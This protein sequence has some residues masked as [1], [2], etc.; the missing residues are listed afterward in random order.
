MDFKIDSSQFEAISTLVGKKF[1]SNQSHFERSLKQLGLL[2]STTQSLVLLITGI[3]GI[4]VVCKFDIP[5][6]F[7]IVTKEAF[8][9]ENAKLANA[10]ALVDLERSRIE[11]ELAELDAKEKMK[12]VIEIR[13]YDLILERGDVINSE[14]ISWKGIFS[15]E[16]VN[17]GSYGVD[18]TYSTL[19]LF[20]GVIDNSLRGINEF[21]L[22]NPPKS[23]FHKSSESSS[24]ASLARPITWNRMI[25][26]ASTT[27]DLFA[28]TTG[29]EFF[30]DHLFDDVLLSEGLLVGYLASG[31]S[32]KFEQEFT[33]QASVH[34]YIGVAF[35]FGSDDNFVVNQLDDFVI[36]FFELDQ[37][38]ANNSESEY[39]TPS[40]K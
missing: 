1:S 11:S 9:L 8:Q 6:K 15:L 14:V 19:E 13:S 34:D 5:T 26:I 29:E 28:S 20:S 33:F 25:G 10:Q 35:I 37:F 40:V 17:N 12:P 16:V 39:H 4:Y 31:K 23:V 18:I 2:V 36:G 3:L 7:G 24:I 22:I 21:A 30:E 32:A 27:P 38:L